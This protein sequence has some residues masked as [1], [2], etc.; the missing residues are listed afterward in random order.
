M[1]P[2]QKL[3]IYGGGLA[4]EMCVAALS[5]LLPT[6]IA[7]VHIKT[8]GSHSSDIFFGTVTSQSIYDFL[9][10]IGVS[11]PEIL[12][13]T[14][15]AFSLGT[16]YQ[17]WGAEKREWI[18][19]FHTPLPLFDGV[20]FHHFLKRRQKQTSEKIPLENYIMSVQAAKKNVFAHPPEGKNNPLKTVEYGYHFSPEDWR[21]FFAARNRKGRAEIIENEISKT[22]IIQHQI[23]AIHLNAGEKI[24]ADLFIDCSTKGALISKISNESGNVSGNLTAFASYVTS[25]KPGS[26]CRSLHGAD[27]GWRSETSL[28]NALMELTVF[29]PED[30]GKALLEHKSLKFTEANLTL[31]KRIE[32]WTGNCVAMGQA[33]ATME[34]LTPAPIILLQNDIERILELFP[35]SQDMTVEQRE[36]NRRFNDNYDHMALFS[37]AFFKTHASTQSPYWSE[38]LSNFEDERLD[39]KITQFESRGILVQY[40]YEPFSAE[41]WTMLH[42]GM[43][44]IPKRYD[45]LA[46][47]IAAPQIEQKLE[48]I[49]KAINMMANKMPPNHIYMSGLLKYLR[50]KHDES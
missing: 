18:Q 49:K 14:Q 38:R 46:E 13:E 32:P 45:P 12:L 9:L 35:V 41:D 48:Q 4:A 2:I 6:D 27:F 16:H 39:I 34:P 26:I 7:I 40:D 43:G 1:L 24:E 37:Q 30:R 17:N 20:G 8:N 5:H 28:Q 33:A 3:V 11:E 15:T 23:G 36:Y 31:F 25:Q 29:L 22:D 44:R 19:S 10:N 50:K 21:N 47:K 42:F